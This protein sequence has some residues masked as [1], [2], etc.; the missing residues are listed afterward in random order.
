MRQAEEAA[1]FLEHVGE[2]AEPKAFADD[3]EEITV[4]AFGW[5][6]PF[7]SG[8]LARSGAGEAHEHRAPGRVA[9]IADLPIVALSAPVGEIGSAD[10][11]G[12]LAK[13]LRQICGINTGHQATSRSE[14]REIGQRLRS[15]ASTP[16]PSGPTGTKK[17]SFHEMISLKRPYARS[18]SRI[19]SV[20][21][22]N[23]IR[24]TPMTR[25]RR[26]CRPSVRSRIVLPSISAA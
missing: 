17:R 11:L 15:L 2:I 6:L 7:A 22:V 24:F 3:V 4:G 5:I 8:T 14:M 26:S 9:D 12:L 20:N 16:A 10:S 19:P 18:R 21:P 25:D 13:A 1:G 23:S